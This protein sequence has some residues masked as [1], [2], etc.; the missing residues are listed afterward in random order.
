MGRR[1]ND[2]KDQRQTSLNIKHTSEKHIFNVVNK[3][4]DIRNPRQTSLNINDT[5]QTLFLWYG[6]LEA[7]YHW[8]DTVLIKHQSKTSMTD[9]FDVDT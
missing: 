7:L 6:K 3:N 1:N 8:T 2:I 4:N 9:S 5:Y